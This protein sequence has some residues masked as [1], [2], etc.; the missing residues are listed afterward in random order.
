MDETKA[1]QIL[2]GVKWICENTTSKKDEYYSYYSS[3]YSSEEEIS[4][5]IV[6]DSDCA[7]YLNN[8][9]VY[10]GISPSYPDHPIADLVKVKCK[11]DEKN[12]VKIIAYYFGAD[13]FSSYCKGPSRLKF[14]FVSSSFEILLGSDEEVLSI[15]NASYLSHKEKEISPQLG[16]SY[17]FDA[18]KEDDLSSLHKSFLVA[19][20]GEIELR[21][22]KKC[23]HAGRAINQIRKIGTGHYLIDFSKEVVGHLDLE[24]VSKTKQH[25]LIT[26][27]EHKENNSLVYKIGSRDFSIDYITKPG[28]NKF[29]DTF[30]RIGL[31]YMEIFCQDDIDIFYFG[32][33]EVRYPFEEIKYKIEDPLVK[34]IYDTCV[35]TLWCCYHEHYEDCPW[36]E[37]CLYTMDS[38]MQALA[39]SV[40]FE[41]NEQIKSSL[42][43]ISQDFRKDKL[44]SIC[45]PSSSNLTIP[46]FSLFY[47]QTVEFY[48]KKTNDLE[49]VRSIYPKLKDILE[50]FLSNYKD[51]LVYTFDK[52]GTWN[53]YEWS[54]GLDGGLMQKQVK[55]ADLILNCL[56]VISL[57]SF[58]AISKS[59][60]KQT[61]LEY[62]FEENKK[63]ARKEFFFNGYFKMSKDNE[64]LSQYGNA[65]AILA[66]YSNDDESK[67]IAKEL[68]NENT[69]FVKATLV[70]KP[71]LY[72]ALLK[73]SPL[74]KEYILKDIKK[75]YG[76]MLDEG[77]TT[78]YETELG[79][80]DFDNAG[81]LCH[82]WSSMP[83]FYFSRFG[84]LK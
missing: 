52:Q 19:D 56:F 75:V 1:I 24:F 12:V 82:G 27:A 15:P 7:V 11:K 36:R 53:F 30:R 37:Q 33:N 46:S 14:A 72:D 8:S 29:L 77:A 76:K 3:F 49:F 64:L 70:T 18:N 5:L 43:L 35:Y 45:S 71:F 59:I 34:K 84:L 38:L 50:A 21:T 22:N 9:L 55:K 73:V 13:T 31:R 10:F 63:A 42:K 58:I 25:I 20:Y 16:Y 66:G 39:G 78:F 79:Y 67:F 32:I 28:Q 44:L 83:I 51:G 17:F 6:C 61:N 41:N 74:Y 60:G 69:L 40:C 4:L 2:N 47:F 57:R 62:I 48:L 26:Y 81:S 23:F 54:N 68:T 80:K 65:L